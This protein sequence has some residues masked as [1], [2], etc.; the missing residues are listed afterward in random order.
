L[1][2]LVTL[3]LITLRGLKRWAEQIDRVSGPRIS[4]WRVEAAL[5][6]L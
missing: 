6:R 5:K 1:L 3:N 4:L 2:Y